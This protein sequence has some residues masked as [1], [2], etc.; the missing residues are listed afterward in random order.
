MNDERTSTFSIISVKYYLRWKCQ[1]GR[2]ICD[3]LE[4]FLFLFLL[5]FLTE[6]TIL[7]P[8]LPFRKCFL[9]QQ[10]QNVSPKNVSKKSSK[11]IHLDL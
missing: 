11:L 4:R 8:S 7:N 6:D 9:S 1:V 5:L 2:N 10:S 3:L